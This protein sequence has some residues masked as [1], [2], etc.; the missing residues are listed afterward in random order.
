MVNDIA[1]AARASYLVARDKD[2]LSMVKYEEVTILT[3]EA[4]LQLLRTPST[5]A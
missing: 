5:T 4:F 3:P 2:L 1:V